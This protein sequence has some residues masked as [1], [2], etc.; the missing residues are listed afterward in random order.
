MKTSVN[1]RRLYLTFVLSLHA[2]AAS[3]LLAAMPGSSPEQRTVELGPPANL[4]DLAVKKQPVSWRLPISNVITNM[5]L[6]AANVSTNSLTFEVDEKNCFIYTAPE[7]FDYLAIEDLEPW[8]MPG[9]PQLPMK[10]FIVRLDRNVEV[11]GVEVVD[12]TYREMRQPVNIVPVPLFGGPNDGKYILNEA[13]SKHRA[14]VFFPGT[15]VACD[16]GL[17]NQHQHVFVRFFPVQ[18]VPGQRKAVLVT[19]ATIRLYYGVHTKEDSASTGDSDTRKKESAGQ[20]TASEAACVVICPE[21]LRH[22]ADR[23]SEF[24]TKAEGISSTVVTTEAIGAT[25]EPAGHPPFSGYADRQLQG[26]NTI[27]NY[28]YTL[29]RQ[30]VA[31]L[32]DRAMH[33]GLVYVTILGDGLLVPPSYY[34]FGKG[35][36]ANQSWVPTDFFYASPDYD[37]VPNH[38]VGRLSVNDAAEAERLVDKI[39]RWHRNAKWEWFRNVWLAGGRGGEFEADLCEM[40][41]DK[42][43]ADGLFSGMQVKKLYHKDGRLDRAYLLPALTTASVGILYYSCH[44]TLSEVRLDS[45]ILTGQD[46]LDSRRNDNVPVVFSESCNNGNF[47]LDLM[48]F[49]FGR[50]GMQPFGHSFGECVLKS[51]AGGIAFFGMTRL[52]GGTSLHYL[53]GGE[54]RVTKAMSHTAMMR[55]ALRSYHRGSDTL[56]QLYSDALYSY[57]ANNILFGPDTRWVFQFVLLGDPALKIPVRP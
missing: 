18:Y 47:D 1:A 36:T 55:Y 50:Y 26:W 16:W 51:P 29:A 40:A 10:T 17:D 20:I 19:R 3:V 42:A 23:L 38:A 4:A 25:Y 27:T 11:Y 34:S 9:Q 35:E 43:E 2:T 39:I 46:V 13:L 49:P 31:Y 56:G 22:Q 41:F 33:P 45:T 54:P 44:G 14:N 7:G 57:V 52:G 28:Q 48:T 53:Q 15:L 30:I 21:V 8:T 5:K 24:H 6:P 32:R 12:G 37:F